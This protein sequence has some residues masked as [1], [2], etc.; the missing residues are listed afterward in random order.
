MAIYSGFSH[1]KIV[2]FNSYV[3]LPEGN[4]GY[5]WVPMSLPEIA[6]SLQGRKFQLKTQLCEECQS[7]SNQLMQRI[8]DHRLFAILP[9]TEV[10]GR[11]SHEKTWDSSISRSETGCFC[12]TSF[13]YVHIFLIDLEP[14]TLPTMD[15][16]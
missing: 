9:I 15:P 12:P 2:I 13:S 1:K 8:D 3:K 4:S 6:A 7:G 5:I 16:V 14:W 10:V 11:N